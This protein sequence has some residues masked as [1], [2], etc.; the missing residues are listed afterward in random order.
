[1][2]GS[3]CHEAGDLGLDT[4]SR[5]FRPCVCHVGINVDIPKAW[6]LS[7]STT[8]IGTIVCQDYYVLSSILDLNT[9]QI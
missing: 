5:N 4:V 9:I 1:M 3:E 8:K 2:T 6:L 7:R